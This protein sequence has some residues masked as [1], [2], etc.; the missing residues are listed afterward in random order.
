[1][2]HLTHPHLLFIA[3]IFIQCLVYA[4]TAL[5]ILKA[6][7]RMTESL[8]GRVLTEDDLTIHRSYAQIR[9]WLYRSTILCAVLSTFTIY[10]T[11]DFVMLCSSWG[12]CVVCA[13]GIAL[14]ASRLDTPETT[15]Y[16]EV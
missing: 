9:S 14:R 12:I 5:I 10:V 4:V 16:V 2:H 8:Q 3:A 13:I 15:V 11:S 7:H 6:L 1:M